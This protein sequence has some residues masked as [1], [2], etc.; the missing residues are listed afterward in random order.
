[1]HLDD[2]EMNRLGRARSAS[3]TGGGGSLFGGHSAR[4][5]PTSLSDAGTATHGSGGIRPDSGIGSGTDGT[6]KA[7]MGR[8]ID[9]F[10]REEGS[11]PVHAHHGHHAN[12]NPN[13][14]FSVTDADSNEPYRDDPTARP[15]VVVRQH[16][17]ERYYDI[18]AANAKT[19]STLLARELKGRHLQMIAISGSIG[20]GLFV[21]SGR[22][23]STGGPASVL[24]AYMIV[25]VMLWCTVQAL[26]EMAVVFPVAGSFSAFSTRFLDPSWGFAMGWK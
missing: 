2:I 12:V 26:G 19:A 22:A 6:F 21:A 3:A 16:Q 9:S 18:R 10:R 20:T 24:L 13:F 4:H 8:F 17:G 7:R 14:A 15:P 1:M 11:Y 5:A 25:G 23:L